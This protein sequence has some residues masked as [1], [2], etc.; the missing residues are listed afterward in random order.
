V[1]IGKDSLPWH[2]SFVVAGRFVA[3]LGVRRVF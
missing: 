2:S 3:R 1:A